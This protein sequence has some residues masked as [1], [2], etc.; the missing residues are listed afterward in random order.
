MTLERPTF[1]DLT[2]DLNA[3]LP[4]LGAESGEG[5]GPSLPTVGELLAVVHIECEEKIPNKVLMHC[6][7]LIVDQPGKQALVRATTFLRNTAEWDAAV[8]KHQGRGYK[9]PYQEMILYIL[10][11]LGE[12]SIPG[13]EAR[14]ALLK[15]GAQILMDLRQAEE[16]R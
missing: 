13:R 5:T 4:Q 3:T 12:D 14:R 1:V 7:R 15:E 9:Q 10:Q 2:G 8:E 16:A 11:T 6:Y